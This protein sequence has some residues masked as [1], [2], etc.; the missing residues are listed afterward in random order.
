[1]NDNPKNHIRICSASK[2]CQYDVIIICIILNIQLP[3]KYHDCQVGY[4]TEDDVKSL[5]KAEKNI[6][7]HV[8]DNGPCPAG[9][10]LF[11][12]ST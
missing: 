2:L 7:D 11:P 3:L 6:I 8:I 9:I 10:L 1:M 4:I 12:D 5:S